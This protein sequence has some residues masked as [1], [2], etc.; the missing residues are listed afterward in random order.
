MVDVPEEVTGF[1]PQE[2]LFPE[3]PIADGAIR[4]LAF[5]VLEYSHEPIPIFDS[6]RGDKNREI[7]AL[8]VAEI[9]AR[10]WKLSSVTYK[11][12]QFVLLGSMGGS[13]AL[14]TRPKIAQ[15]TLQEVC[16]TAVDWLDNGPQPARLPSWEGPRY[17]KR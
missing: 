15:G 16:R 17:S 12:G 14:P 7:E 8:V 3:A 6:E 10:G 11:A 4:M 13:V 1:G 2:D 9:N 5:G